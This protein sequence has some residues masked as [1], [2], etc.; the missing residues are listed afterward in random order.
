MSGG[1]DEGI[2]TA[3]VDREV[4]DY[5]LANI[6]IQ[7]M[8][9]YHIHPTVPG[10]NYFMPANATNYP[11]HQDIGT[12]LKDASRLVKGGYDF[13]FDARILTH[14]GMVVI[15]PDLNLIKQRGTFFGPVVTIFPGEKFDFRTADPW[16]NVP[17]LGTEFA[18][19]EFIPLK[20]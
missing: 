4:W 9:S 7:E 10:L 1:V 14:D 13:N 15:R 16:K 11:S 19:T 12:A 3:N 8:T 18:K 5:I 2:G 20:P 17:E 6:N